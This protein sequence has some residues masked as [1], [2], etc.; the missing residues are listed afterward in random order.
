MG[1]QATKLAIFEHRSGA[2][3]KYESTEA[4]KGAICS[5]A[6]RLLDQTLR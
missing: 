4:Q 5:P 3:M 2:Y 6:W 1:A